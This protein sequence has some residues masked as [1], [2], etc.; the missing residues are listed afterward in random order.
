MTRRFLFR[1]LIP[2]AALTLS[3]AIGL[4]PASASTGTWQISAIVGDPTGL[5]SFTDVA[6]SGPNNAWVGG[7]V[8]TDNLGGGECGG[9]TAIVEQWNGQSWQGVTLPDSNLGESGYPVVIGT[10]SADNTWIFG[11]EINDVGYGVQVTASGATETA[12]PADGGIAFSGAA[13]F[14]P[15]DAWAFGLSGDFTLD[16]FTNYAAHYNG[17]TWT[18]LPAPPV[19]P[20]YVS[21][22]SRHDLWILGPPSFTSGGSYEAARWTGSG[23]VTISLPTAADLNLPASTAFQPVSILGLSRHNV[24]V[25]A[26]VELSTCC[27]FGAG[28]LLLHWN[29]AN[30]SL[31][32]TPSTSVVG[33]F[34]SDLASDGSGGLWVSGYIDQPTFAGPYLYHYS[35]GQWS[36]QLAPTETGLEPQFG[37][38]AWIPGTR[39][40]WGAAELNNAPS[41]AVL[42]N[43]GIIYQYSP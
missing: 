40:L 9:Q 1:A 16:N 33:Q 5:T 39:S 24:W 29:G 22:L 30:W 23:W 6:A 41:G 15:D 42:A 18:Q 37:D 12:L 27:G 28:V 21:A 43:Q 20:Q 19:E 8:C 38:L 17:Q 10:S 34:D 11:S 13:V 7:N 14:G 35:H 25:T 26:N 36:E 31:G 2:A 4:A 32:T 3:G